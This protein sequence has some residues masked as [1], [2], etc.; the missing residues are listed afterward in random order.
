MAVITTGNHP[1][2]LWPGINKWFGISYAEKDQQWPGVFA[3]NTSDKA[4]EEDVEATSFGLAVVKTQGGAVSYDSHSQQYTARYTHITYG[5]GWIVTE[6]EI[7]DNQ[8]EQLASFRTRAL[9]FSM[10]Q[11]KET[12]A[13]NVLNRAFDSN[14]TGA[15]SKELCATDHPS[16]YGS[17]SNELS[18]AADL[19]E[20]ALETLMIQVRNARNNRG[21]KIA[22]VPK[23][24]IVAPENQFEAH[25]IVN[26]NLRPGTANN[27]I[28]ALRSMGMLPDGVMVYDYLTTVDDFFLKTDAPDSLKL[29]QR[30]PYRFSKDNDFDTNNAKAKGIERFSV[31]WSDWRG[32]YGSVGV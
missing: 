17:Q 26:T 8:Y 22:L 28:N 19:S 2:A 13:A 1:K 25:R 3:K 11:T 6:E 16:V 14:Y 31:G 5:L 10:R 21:L 20:A 29:F 12:V 30:W 9:A 27:D 15:D 32:L 23:K 4:Y 24:L 18:P 7:S